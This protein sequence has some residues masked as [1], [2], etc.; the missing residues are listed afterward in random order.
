MSWHCSQAL[1]A[2]FSRVD[3]SAG[4]RSAESKSTRTA[5]ECSCK[6][7]T[8][9]CSTHSRFGTTCERLTELPGAARWMSS[10]PDSPASHS[11]QRASSL[12]KKT[13]ETCGRRPHEYLAKYDPDGRCWRTSQRSLLA[14]TLVEFSETW[15]REGITRDMQFV[16]RHDMEPISRAKGY[17][18][19]PRTPRPVACDGKGAGRMNKSRLQRIYGGSPNL[20]DWCAVNLSMAY[21]PVRLAEYLMGWPIGW[22]DLK[23]LA[24]DKYQSWLAAHGVNCPQVL[25]TESEGSDDE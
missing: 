9:E 3:C 13:N 7:K 24:T 15:P 1:V 12:K 8:T 20:R 4:E 5:A 21:P 18:S 17:G 16:A 25:A 19:L 10:L 22:T 23:P 6:D 14:D 2:D 11:A